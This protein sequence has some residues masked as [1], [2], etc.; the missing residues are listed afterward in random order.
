MRKT[1]TMRQL[2]EAIQDCARS[3]EEVVAVLAHLMNTGRVLLARG[4]APLTTHALA[5]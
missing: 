2:V 4:R 1:I 3:E 5:A